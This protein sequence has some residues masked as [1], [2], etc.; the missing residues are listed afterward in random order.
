MFSV[1]WWEWIIPRRNSI[2]AANFSIK[3]FCDKFSAAL[4]HQIA[5]GG[6]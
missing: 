1:A 3:T 4:I 2:F 5:S 6:S